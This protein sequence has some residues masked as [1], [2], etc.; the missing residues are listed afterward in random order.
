MSLF[1]LE[2]VKRLAIKEEQHDPAYEETCAHGSQQAFE[3]HPSTDTGIEI[4][5]SERINN[6]VSGACN[7]SPH[8]LDLVSDNWW[9][10]QPFADQIPDI[11]CSNS[12]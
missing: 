3:V 7:N 11:R 2:D 12:N 10:M 6:V 9:T 1:I 5:C 4:L 8:S